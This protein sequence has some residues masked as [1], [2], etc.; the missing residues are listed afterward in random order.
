MPDGPGIKFRSTFTKNPNQF[1]VNS[2][3]DISLI[4]IDSIFNEMHKIDVLKIDV[5]GT[6]Y[7][8]LEGLGSLRPA[9]IQCEVSTYEHY[10]DQKTLLD[11][12][13]LLDNYGYFPIVLP[14]LYGHGDAIFV[15]NFN[16]KGLK[17]YS[18]HSLYYEFILAIYGLQSYGKWSTVYFDQLLNSKV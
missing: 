18:Q 7:E 6:E 1:V 17:I 4:R 5:Q 9:L 13:T 2:V 16:D 14:G 8:I 11:I 12:M 15:P 10:K 3:Q